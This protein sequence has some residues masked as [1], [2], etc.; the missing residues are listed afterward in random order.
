MEAQHHL[1]RLTFGA[2]PPLPGPRTLP[3][4]VAVALSFNGTTQAVMMASPT[5]L[6]DFAYGFALSEGIATPQEIASV[7][8]VETQDGIDLQIWLH[9]DAEARLAGRRRTMAGQ[10]GA[11]CVASIRWP[12]PCARRVW[13]RRPPSRWTLPR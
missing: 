1:P 5:D 6:V 9:D 3:A 10:W 7:D 4:E 12:R 13:C 2:G 8:P 11:D